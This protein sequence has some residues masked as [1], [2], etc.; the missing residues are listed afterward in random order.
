MM[1]GDIRG[2]ASFGWN[3]APHREETQFPFV[4]PGRNEDRVFR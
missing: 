3:P 2:D 4:V 1:G